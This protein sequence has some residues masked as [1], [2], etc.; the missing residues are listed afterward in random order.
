MDLPSPVLARLHLAKTAGTV[1]GGAA[2]RR[3]VLPL[4]AFEPIL[5]LA[6]QARPGQSSLETAGRVDKIAPCSLSA[7]ARSGRACGWLARSG[8][9]RG[10][11]SITFDSCTVAR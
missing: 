5:A 10:S 3:D 8:R 2:L 9:V 6:D 1:A 11:V 4:Q 7:K